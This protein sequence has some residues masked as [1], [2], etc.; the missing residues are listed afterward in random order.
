MYGK[1]AGSD[2][3]HGQVDAWDETVTAHRVRGG[4]PND[5]TGL[6][7]FGADA[8]VTEPP[9][10]Q[11]PMVV[12][13]APQAFVKLLGKG[14]NRIPLSVSAFEEIQESGCHWAVGY[15]T[16]KRPRS[17]EDDAV[18]FMGRLTRD[19]NN[20]RV[21][22]WAIGMQHKPGRDDATLAD[23]QLRPWKEQWSRYTRVNRAE[24]VAGTMANGVSL[25]ELMDT[26]EADSFVSTKRNAAQGRGNTNPRHAYR[27]QAAVELSAEGHSWLSERLQ[28]AFEVHGKVPQD[29]LDTLD[30]PDLNSSLIG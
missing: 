26:L 4:R 9:P 21:F 6:D 16:S 3:Q 29:S 14:D 27:Q 10:V 28:V 23:I 30:R 8:G 5:S 17:V 19:P 25:N 15:P 1:G 13:D 24:F 2:L 20:I 7:D 11:V 12:A 22:G 18:I